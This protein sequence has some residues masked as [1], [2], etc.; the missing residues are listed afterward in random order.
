MAWNYISVV[1]TFALLGFQ[2]GA[3]TRLL[4]RLDLAPRTLAL[5]LQL[6][7]AGAQLGN[8][9]LGEQLLQGPLL[10]ILSLVLLEL[11]DEGDG[12]L[13]D[14]TL[15]LFTA[16]DNLGQLIDSFVDGLT[17][18]AFDWQKLAYG[19]QRASERRDLRYLPCGCP[20]APCAIP[21][22]PRLACCL[23]RDHRQID[24]RWRCPC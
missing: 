8:G 15:V 4:P 24:Q 5:R 3:L 2:A 14:G 20:C 12:A 6:V 21:R 18:T 16:G 9:L 10:N 1:A 13:K 23:N 19:P 22:T 11:C 7:V 17:T